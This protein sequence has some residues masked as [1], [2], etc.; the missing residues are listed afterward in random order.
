MN[1]LFWLTGAQMAR[2]QPV[3]PK[4]RGKPRVEWD[5]LLQSQWVAPERCPKEYGPPKTLYNRWKGR[6]G[7]VEEFTQGRVVVGRPWP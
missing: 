1:N 4:N 6:G 3:F 7:P 5:N 2:L